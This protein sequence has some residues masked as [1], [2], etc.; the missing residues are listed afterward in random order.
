MRITK[1][2]KDNFKFKKFRLNE[3]D[4]AAFS[5]DFDDSS[6]RSVSVPHDWGIEGDFAAENDMTYSM[7]VQDG[8]TKAGPQ[9]G[10]TG[11]LPIVGVIPD[12]DKLERVYDCVGQIAA[13]NVLL[14]NNESDPVSREVLAEADAFSADM[15]H[16]H[17]DIVDMI[18]MAINQAYNQKG[19]F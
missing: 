4:A 15:S 12:K 19:L 8:M 18:T 9:T 5:P 3:T 1:A 16:P 2:L 17:D 7:I 14:P 13:G 11:G 6:W 10:R